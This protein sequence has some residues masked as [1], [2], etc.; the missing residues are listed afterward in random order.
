MKVS[1]A[2]DVMQELG[3]AIAHKHEQACRKL[4]NN[5]LTDE[6]GHALRGRIAALS[7]FL[8]LVSTLKVLYEAQETLAKAKAPPSPAAAPADQAALLENLRQW[9]AKEMTS[10]EGSGWYAQGRRDIATELLK[11]L[12]DLDNAPEPPSPK[13]DHGSHA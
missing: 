9:A 2:A 6:E 5:L 4:D 1:T 7:E 13:E 12:S 3:H 11:R 8:V 10:A